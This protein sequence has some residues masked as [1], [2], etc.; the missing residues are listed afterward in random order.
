MSKGRIKPGAFAV[1][2]VTA[3]LVLTSCG[4]N[5]NSPAVVL[6]AAELDKSC[7]LASGIKLQNLTG[8]NARAGRALPPPS[9][10]SANNRVVE[11][12]T[13]IAGQDVTYVFACLAD[14]EGRVFVSPAG[15]K[16]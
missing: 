10:Y 3:S 15:Y 11:L 12:D 13:T 1:A 7:I 8:Q 5:P 16:P 14:N 4:Q 9:G 6:P 2:A